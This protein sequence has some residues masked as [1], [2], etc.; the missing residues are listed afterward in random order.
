MKPFAVFAISFRDNLLCA[1]TREDGSVGLAGGKVDQGEMPEVAVLR[2]AEEEG[3]LLSNPIFYRS[4]M[5]E[6]KL[7]AWYFCDFVAKLDSYKE[8]YRGIKNVFLPVEEVAKHFG[9]QFLTEL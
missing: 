5:V 7:V 8:A 1:T 3:F 2:E 4:A 9:N 6:G